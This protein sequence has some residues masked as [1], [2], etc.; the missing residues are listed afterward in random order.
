MDEEIGVA[1]DAAQG[2]EVKAKSTHKCGCGDMG[3]NQWKNMLDMDL[4][5]VQ[6][7][8]LVGSIRGCLIMK[9]PR[10]NVSLR[11][12]G[13]FHVEF[14]RGGERNNLRVSR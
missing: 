11:F 12:F 1:I 7:Q 9:G 3:A 6:L 8:L 5:Y 2:C 4:A 10:K 13:D 14:G